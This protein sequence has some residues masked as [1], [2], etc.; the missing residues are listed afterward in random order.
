M[1]YNILITIQNYVL[2]FKRNVT[3]LLWLFAFV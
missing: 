3:I 1:Q 2:G